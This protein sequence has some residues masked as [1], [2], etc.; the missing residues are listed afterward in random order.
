MDLEEGI[1]RYNTRLILM[2]LED[3]VIEEEKEKEM[4]DRGLLK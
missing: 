2:G 1:K 3:Y 4:K